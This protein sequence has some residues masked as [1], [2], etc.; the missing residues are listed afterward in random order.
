[1]IKYNF[2]I[3][4]DEGIEKVVIV[5]KLPTE[6]EPLVCIE[7]PN[8][9]GKSTLLNMIALGCWGLK[10]QSNLH[11][12]LR[13]KLKSLIEA[14]HQEMTF[15]IQIDVQDGQKLYLEK[16]KGTSQEMNVYLSEDGKKK[17]LSFEEFHRRFS[18]IYDIPQNPIGRV[19]ELTKDL[20]YENNKLASR[21]RQMDDEVTK[22]L[23]DIKRSRDPKR[24]KQVEDEIIQFNQQKTVFEKSVQQ[25]KKEYEQ[26]KIYF[27]TKIYVDY[28]NDVLSLQKRIKSVEGTA[29]EEKKKVKE[30]DAELKNLA[31]MVKNKFDRIE[32]LIA[33]VAP[34]LRKMFPKGS[35]ILDHWEMGRDWQSALPQ[36][37]RN[38]GLGSGIKFF[39]DEISSF[40]EKHSNPEK[41][42]EAEFLEALIQTLENFQDY[43]VVVPG[44]N[45]NIKQFISLLQTKLKECGPIPKIAQDCDKMIE[46]LDG[47]Y[48]AREEFLSQILTKIIVFKKKGQNFDYKNGM[49]EDDL[50]NEKDILPGLKTKL[51]ELDTKR[52]KYL[53]ECLDLGIKEND[54]FD[55]CKSYENAGNE[56]KRF[57]G[58]SE[59]ECISILTDK[60]N[61]ITHEMSKMSAN[62]AHIKQREGEL[63]RLKEKEPHKYQDYVSELNDLH[64]HITRLRQLVDIKCKTYLEEV[65]DGRNP[66]SKD[67]D[68][69]IFLEHLWLYL[70]SRIKKIRH[71]VDEYIVDK[72]DLIKKIVCVEGGRIIRLDDMGTGQQQAAYLAGLLTKPNSGKII[73][74][75]D[76]VAMMDSQSIK[77]IREA[78]HKLYNNGRLLIGI[79]VQKSDQIRISPL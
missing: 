28:G 48:T 41:V 63:K 65:I 59:A 38:D 45:T 71:G 56:F 74:L 33:K 54:I 21:L 61:S 68:R 30:Y 1:M 73:A 23:D 62:D 11:P 42:A 31:D 69:A 72:I 3:V 51:K 22:I 58:Y 9:V 77:P 39:N 79:I 67:S 7:G 55:I 50:P 36:G 53:Q 37:D 40:K 15:D 10:P 4:R 29:R 6:M 66:V 14:K 34:R 12:E 57:A 35:E 43:R 70:G 49:I 75:L 2:K 76:E 13:E 17:P 16:Q 18:L 19:K 27:F 44:V 46:C 64:G 32:E 26:Y 24:I 8:S 47:I 20:L 60:S 5:P 25:L 52:Q 78:L